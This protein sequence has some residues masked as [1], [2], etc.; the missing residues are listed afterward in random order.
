MNRSEY[1]FGSW[2]CAYEVSPVDSPPSLV[3]LQT[4]MREVEGHETGWPV[5]LTLSN[6]PEMRPRPVDGVLEC[7]LDQTQ[8]KDFWRADPQGRMFLIRRLQEDTREINGAQPGTIFELTLP[9]WRT[10]ECLLH[11]FRLASRLEAEHVALQMTWTGLANRTLTAWASPE[12]W[13]EPSRVC[14]TDT[15]RSRI[16]VDAETI[17]DTLPELVRSLVQPLYEQ[18][19]LFEP[20]ADIYAVEMERLRSRRH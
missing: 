16:A 7:W 19:D 3:A 20:P 18:F 11:A 12:R 2:R 5:W 4:M 14:M 9:I 17:S 15:V 6:R 1:D 10:G 8:D 13:L